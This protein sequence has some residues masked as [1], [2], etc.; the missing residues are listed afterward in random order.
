MFLSLS[1]RR[2]TC[3]VDER[4]A[5]NS[6][7]ATPVCKTYLPALFYV[8]LRTRIPYKTPTEALPSISFE[9]NWVSEKCMALLGV[10]VMG[11]FFRRTCGVV[12]FCFHHL[13]AFTSFR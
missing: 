9:M 2:V 12:A 7:A 5:A 10:G 6:A 11:S 8:Y 4:W 13:T 1:R 3:I